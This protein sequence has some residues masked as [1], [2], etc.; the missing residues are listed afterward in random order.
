MKTIVDV[1]LFSGAVVVCCIAAIA[2]LAS[3]AWLIYS[4]TRLFIS[5]RIFWRSSA[6]YGR[7]VRLFRSEK[8]PV[9]GTEMNV[10]AIQ[11]CG[12]CGDFLECEFKC[13]K[14]DGS[15]MII[16]YSKHECRKVRK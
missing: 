4:I 8:M 14:K 1:I 12:L 7:W 16:D 11:Y 10:I 6:Q 13:Y 9:P 3:L 2:A 5:W 15:G